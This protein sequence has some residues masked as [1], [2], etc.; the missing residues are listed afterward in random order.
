MGGHLLRSW[1]STQATMALSSGEA[2][3]YALVGGVGIGIGLQELF[4][5]LG[6]EKVLRVFTD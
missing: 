4:R 6:E 2:E 1:I 5:D 3:H